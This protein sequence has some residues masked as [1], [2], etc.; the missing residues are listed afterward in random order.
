MT[1]SNAQGTNWLHSHWLRRLGVAALGGAL[2]AY[3]LG[4]GHYKWPPFPLIVKA[5]T[6]LTQWLPA[7]VTNHRGRQDVLQ[8]AFTDSL[9]ETSLY[10][11]F[12]NSFEGIREANQRL[13][14]HR[15]GF[16]TAYRDIEI[17]DALQVL[18]PVGAQPVVKVRFR[19]QGKDF[20]AFAYGHL[21][22]G[23]ADQDAASLIIP[24]SGLNQSLGIV[25]GDLANYHHGILDA[26]NEGGGLYTH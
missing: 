6:A 12:I 25:T 24:G 3:G 1:A 18:R 9:N 13:L 19:Y 23:G 22:A 11:P 17:L 8:Y 4:V 20:E 14:M 26:L 2:F 15:E 21:P 10:Y 7:L 16:E 5:R